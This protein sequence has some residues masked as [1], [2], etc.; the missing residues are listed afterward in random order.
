MFA[1]VDQLTLSDR[2][3]VETFV[4]QLLG[5]IRLVAEGNSDAESQL[6]SEFVSYLARRA[7]PKAMAILAAL[8]TL[9]PTPA[10]RNSAANL[11]ESL[12]SSGAQVPPWHNTP[13][14]V[15]E[16]WQ[17][18]DVFEESITV[19]WVTQCG[20]T[21]HGVVVVVDNDC[22]PIG[23]VLSDVYVTSTPDEVVEEL[24]QTHTGTLA[25]PAQRTDP[26]GTINTMRAG[27]AELD[28][29]LPVQ[30]PESTVLA[31]R[32]LLAARCRSVTAEL[33]VQQDSI[34]STGPVPAAPTVGEINRILNAFLSS[35][36]AAVL[37]RNEDVVAAVELIAAFH[38][39][40]G[41][42]VGPSITQTFLHDCVPEELEADDD[43]LGVLA[44]VLRAFNAWG[45]KHTGLPPGAAALLDDQTLKCAKHYRQDIPDRGHDIP[46]DWPGLFE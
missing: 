44:D 13:M 39:P 42:R 12:S 7:D 6:G 2:L 46:P 22:P 10:L 35:P 23:P 31:M 37:P 43:M 5:T 45:A 17:G 28:D 20:E 16:C 36:E 8:R 41:L 4:S 15:I 14:R 34:E 32:A 33:P 18:S 30:D 19:L 11:L 40:G 24:R 21:R 3:E 29:E 1:E 25:I 27:L 38:L 26:Y 9:A